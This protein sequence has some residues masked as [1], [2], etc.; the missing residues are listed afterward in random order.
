MNIKDS[1]LQS[2]M[3]NI[4]SALF[5]LPIEL[6][7]E[8]PPDGTTGCVTACVLISGGWDGAVI[9]QSESPLARRCGALMFEST[10]ETISSD[11]VND[12]LGEVANMAGGN[13]KSLLAGTCSLSLPAVVEGRDYIVKVPGS[14]PLKR[15]AFQ[16]EGGVLTLSVLERNT[17]T[18]GH[19]A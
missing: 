17:A 4:W 6:L 13:F 2:I 1:D 9:I 16:S 8:V 12:A 3:E 18:T 10:P 15:L 11:E 5:G 19:A 7:P 14:H